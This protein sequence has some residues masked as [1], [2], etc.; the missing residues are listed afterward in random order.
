LTAIPALPTVL[1]AAFSTG[2]ALAAGGVGV[3]RM[4]GAAADAIV[5]AAGGAG[6]TADGAAAVAGSDG[7]GT[8]VTRV[9]CGG[10][11]AVGV[12][13]LAGCCGAALDGVGAAPAGWADAL[14]AAC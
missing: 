13:L 11:G 14:L 12:P 6:V 5:A 2:G 1:A 4:L 8:G 3:T 10:I 7:A 9:C